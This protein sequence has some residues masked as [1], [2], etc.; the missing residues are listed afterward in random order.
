MAR[1]LK[2]FAQGPEQKSLGDYGTVIARYDAFAIVEVARGKGAALTSRFPCEDITRQY[3]LAFGGK[4]AA[5]PPGAAAKA[6]APALRPHEGAE[7]G[8]SPLPRPVRRAGE[9]RLARP[10]HA[11][12]WQRA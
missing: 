7:S 4:R 3:D 10:D 2:V 11:R 1:M 5:P 12:R 9:E 8:L 6:V